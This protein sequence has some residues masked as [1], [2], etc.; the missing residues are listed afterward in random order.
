MSRRGSARAFALTAAALWVVAVSACGS[1]SGPLPEALVFLQESSLV[2]PLDSES[3]FLLAG[4]F[5]VTRGDYL[6][7]LTTEDAELPMVFVTRGEASSWARKHGLRLPTLAEWRHLA[8]GGSVL[9]VDRWGSAPRPGIANTLE[10]GLDRPL[11]VGVFERSRTSLGCYDLRGNVWEWVRSPSSR[12]GLPAR[13]LACGGS[14]AVR[15]EHSGPEALRVLE[16]GEAA[17]DIGFRVVTEARPYL[18][19]RIL[20]LWGDTARRDAIRRAIAHWRPEER[21]ALAVILEREGFPSGF[22]A[23]LR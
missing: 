7:D 12:D 21:R 1:D 20:P 22:C 10:L 17:D 2:P 13:A 6:G 23:A 14:F 18:R 19:E 3:P 8:T 4:R 15:L 16:E 5:E 9:P 11:P